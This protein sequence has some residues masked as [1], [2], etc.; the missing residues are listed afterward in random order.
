MNVAPLPSFHASVKADRLPLEKL[1]GN[2]ALTE[3]EKIQELSRQFE[4]L[5]VRQILK[6]A[7]KSVIKSD[8]FPQSLSSDIYQDM[9][10]SQLADSISHSG[11]LGLAQHLEREFLRQETDLNSDPG[12][13]LED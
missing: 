10:N 13:G 3:K 6:D 1:A 8:L 11:T 7:R 5:L 2:A 4:A 12:D 9:I